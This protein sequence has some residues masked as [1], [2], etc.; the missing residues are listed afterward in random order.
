MNPILNIQIDV[1][2]TIHAKIE[3]A[4]KEIENETGLPVPLNELYVT[5]LEYG[6]DHVA[7]IQIDSIIVANERLVKERAVPLPEL[8]NLST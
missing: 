3:A 7:E 6:V 8:A 4:Q 2:E 1:P 5:A